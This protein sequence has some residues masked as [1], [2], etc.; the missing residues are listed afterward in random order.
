MSYIGLINNSAIQAETQFTATAGQTTFTTPYNPGAVEV[1]VNGVKL[2]DGTD[3]TA[4]DGANIV[5]TTGAIAGSIVEIVKMSY[6][7]LSNTYTQAQSDAKYVTFTGNE[8]ISGIKSLSGG[9]LNLTNTT[10]NVITWTIDGFGPPSFA[11]RTAGS[12]LILYPA[13]VAGT[14]ADYVIG[15]DNLVMWFG[16]PD[17]SRTFKWYM[18]ED[19]YMWLTSTQLRLTGHTNESRSIEI[20]SGRTTNGY[21]HVDL[22]GDTTYTDYGT[23]LIRNNTGANA[24]SVLHH[25]GTGVLQ[26]RAEEGI[27]QIISGGTQDLRF[28]GDANGS[29]YIGNHTT[30][31]M[32]N[33]GGFLQVG[34]TTTHLRLGHQ[35]GTTSGTW[36]HAFYYNS[37]GIGTIAQSGTTAVVYNTSSD[38]RLKTN[39]QDMTNGLDKINQVR[40]ITFTWK[41]DNSPG[42]GF[43]AHELQE[44]FP[45]AVTGEKDAVDEEGNIIPQG[46]DPRM[47]VATLCKAVQELDAKCKALE[48]RLAAAGIA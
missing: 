20:G 17:T 41:A 9:T 12:K 37:V 13:F 46:M 35:N 32:P 28:S 33:G 15:I 11:S 44:V 23:R 1:Y 48:A 18:G 4:T 24:D 38:Y 34:P 39:V 30:S 5:L 14:Q 21:S 25:R 10:S 45:D 16:I 7:E 43:I 31:T 42:Q 8:T 6:V 3:F 29:V 27:V 2:T 19:E 40:P 47:L 22:I 26:L 36:Y